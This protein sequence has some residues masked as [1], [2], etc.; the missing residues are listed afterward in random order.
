MKRFRVAAS[1]VLGWRNQPFWHGGLARI[2]HSVQSADCNLLQAP[3]EQR[4]KRQGDRMR[5]HEKTGY[6]IFGIL[7]SEKPFDPNITPHFA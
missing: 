5:G 2:T 3:E 1:A 6:I 4:E 7:K